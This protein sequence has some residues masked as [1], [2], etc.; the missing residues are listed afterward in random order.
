MF[1]SKALT[2]GVLTPTAITST[3]ILA[4]WVTI[5]SK[6]DNA[7]AARILGPSQSASI[8]TA[9]GY[10]LMPGGSLTL[11]TSGNA[12]SYNLNS[13]Y[14]QAGDVADVFDICWGGI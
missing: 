3:N 13:I 14:I 10:T 1:D 11:P 2:P 6:N 12:T 9:G 5:S 8:Q 7:A 4:G